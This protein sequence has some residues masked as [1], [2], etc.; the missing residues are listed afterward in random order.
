MD[1]GDSGTSSDNYWE[2]YN[3]R[4]ALVGTTTPKYTLEGTLRHTIGYSQQH[5]EAA[6][7]IRL[8]GALTFLYPAQEEPNTLLRTQFGPHWDV[9]ADGVMTIED[10]HTQ[11]RAPRDL[12]LDGVAD[13]T[14]SALLERFLRRAEVGTM[15]NPQR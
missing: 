13:E 12:N 14:D 5:N 15:T 1:S 7:T 10:L 8:P 6:W 9:N 11:A 4:D 2:S 3:L